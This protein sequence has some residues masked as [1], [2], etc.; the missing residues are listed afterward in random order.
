[1]DRNENSLFP[2]APLKLS[3]IINQAFLFLEFGVKV[4][5]H[6]KQGRVNPSDFNIPVE[7]RLEDGIHLKLD[8]P[9]FDS[10]DENH[11]RCSQ[12]GHVD[13]WL[14]CFESRFGPRIGGNRLNC[15][16]S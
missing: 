6:A 2:T 4:F 13:L 7:M 9:V 3:E 5:T 1:M 12:Y 16:R 15:S 11:P 10:P 14:H 8:N